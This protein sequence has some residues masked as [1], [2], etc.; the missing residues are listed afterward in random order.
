[1]E[2]LDQLATTFGVEPLGPDETN[3]LLDAARDVAH[4]VERKITPLASFLL[5]MR[6]AAQ[7][8]DGIPREQALPETLAELRSTL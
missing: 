2:W 6:V 1:M 5:G 3:D 4:G 8:A 7:V